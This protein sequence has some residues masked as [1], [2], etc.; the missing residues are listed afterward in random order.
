MSTTV[1]EEKTTLDDV[2]RRLEA[3]DLIPSHEPLL[4]GISRRFAALERC[5]CRSQQ[6]LRARLKNA[7]AVAAL[8]KDTGIPG[9][10][11][12]VLRRAVEGFFPKPQPW[13]AFPWLPVGTIAKLET[14]GLQTTDELHHAA[15]RGRAALARKTGLP[16]KD[17]A[18]ALALSDLSRIQW[19][20]PNVARTLV[21]AGFARASEV[22]S[23]NPESLCQTVAEINQGRGFYKGKIGLR[24][25]KRLIVAASYVP[26]S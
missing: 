23:A 4:E 12:T 17:L 6:N 11:L 25:I 10:Y 20:S 3:T 16:A 18:E 19:V 21:A 7:K 5:G 2:R 9:Q 22:A 13:A 14:V 8:A 1:D 15:R 26:E 24:D